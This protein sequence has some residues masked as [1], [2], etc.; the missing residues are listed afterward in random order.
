MERWANWLVDN[1]R[2]YARCP[3]LTVSEGIESALSE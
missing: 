1:P 2:D 3:G